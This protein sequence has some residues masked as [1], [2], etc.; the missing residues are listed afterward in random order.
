MS[1][2]ALVVLLDHFADWEA[3]HL[4]PMLNTPP[5]EGEEPAWKSAVVSLT[6]EPIRSMGQL[7]V[8]PDLTISDVP[9][10]FDALILIGGMS[11]RK[12][13]AQEVLPLIERA[14]QKKVPLAAICDAANFLAWHGF[15][16]DAEHTGNAGGE[17]ASHPGSL[18]KNK[19]KF[20]DTARALTD[21][22]IITADGASPVDFTAHVLRALD[23]LPPEVIDEWEDVQLVGEKAFYRE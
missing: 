7:T 19:D 23:V 18:Y 9:E 16:N 8:T 22:G 21:G 10:S 12:E 1:K 4:L 5:T 2:L 13:E 17:M 3:G 14:R 6:K 15:L 11:W 20:D